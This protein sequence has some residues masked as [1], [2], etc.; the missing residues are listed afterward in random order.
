MVPGPD[1][2]WLRPLGSTG[3]TVSAVCLGGAPLGSMPQ[4]FGHEV[5]EA[6]AVELVRSVLDG[7]V[8]FIDTANGYSDGNSERRIG[9]AVAAHG[10]LPPGVVIATK[11]DPRDGDFSGAR[12]RQSVRESRQR[13]GLAE[14]PLV[15]LHDPELFAWETMTGP[16]G[17]VEALSALRADGE[18]GAIGLAG[19]HTPTVSRYLD[20][21]VFDVVL[22]HNRWTL[23]DRGAEPV[24]GF[25]AD[26]GIGVVNAAVYG[27]GI[28]ARQQD[29][30]RRDYAYRPAA[31][32][33]LSAVA[34][35]RQLCAEF[36]TDIATAALQFSLRDPRIASTV[37]G[38][39]RRE[40]L[41]AVLQ[42]ASTTLADEFW[43]RLDRLTPPPAAWLDRGPDPAG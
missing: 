14:L 31:A 43:D 39:S 28:L 29:D 8:T 34:S 33:T 24:I 25:A 32:E 19:G 23:V 15:Y 10:G 2:D 3:L 20:L 37:V 1:T 7:P 21:G 30:G 40:R 16:G 27:G 5:A 17:A 18:V 12:V 4:N 42:S 41:P 36:D 11:V 13:L 9:A 22:V 35:I 26:H 38:I 6:D